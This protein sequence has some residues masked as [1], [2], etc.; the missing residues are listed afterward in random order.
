MSHRGVLAS[1]LGVMIV[2]HAA[3]QKL[4]IKTEKDPDADFTAI[5]TY[6]WLP[7]A[8]MVSHVAPDAVSNPTLSQAALGPHI[9]AAVGRQL[10]ARGLTETGR[11]VADVHVGYFA[12]LTV[13]F[14][15]TYLG[16]YYGYV[17]GWAS[18]VMPG[19]APTT[20]VTIAEKGT[21]LVDIVDRASNRAIWRGSVVTRIHH[22][23]TL[24]QRIVRINEGAGRLFKQFPVRPR[25]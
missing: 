4:E 8:P 7:P 23:R 13:D 9:M 22:E 5:R 17:T 14:N 3:A 11:D 6:A 10:A 15:R 18:P 20:S 24:E 19:L 25:K 16:E 21:V 2:A 1:V 12:A